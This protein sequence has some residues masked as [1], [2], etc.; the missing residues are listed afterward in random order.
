MEYE[1]E[2]AQIDCECGG[3]LFELFETADEQIE[4][5]CIE[6]GGFIELSTKLDS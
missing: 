6:C 2:V 1:I 3:T 5:R 4:Y